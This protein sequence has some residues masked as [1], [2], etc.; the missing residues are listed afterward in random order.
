[1]TIPKGTLDF[2]TD[3][4]KHG[5]FVK[6]F[7]SCIFFDE[8]DYQV[9]W[10]ENAAKLTYDSIVALPKCELY[11]HNG[12]KFD[13]WFLLEWIEPQNIKIINGR[14]AKMT[15][16]KVTLIDSYLLIAEPL[17]NFKKTKISYAKFEKK[18]RE[19]HRNEIIR[20]M[21]DDCR[22][23]LELILGFHKILG[24]KLTIG[25]AAIQSI[26]NNNIK[27]NKQGSFHDSV[28]RPFF[29]GGR[30]ENFEVGH[31]RFK[32]PAKYIDINSAYSF[33]MTHKHPTGATYSITKKFPKPRYKNG[34]LTNGHWFAEID[35]LS[36]GA[37]PYKEKNNDLSFPCDDEVRTYRCT[38]Y[39]IQSALDNDTL[40]IIR[41]H[42]VLCPKK[43]MDFKE[44]V[45]HH[46]NERKEAKAH[47][48]KLKDLVHKKAGNSGYG[49]WATNPEKFYDW[50][51]V[52]IGTNVEDYADGDGYEWYNDIMGKSLWRR[53]ASPWAKEQ[54]YY[55]VATAA[56]ITGFVRAMLWRCLCAVDGK[57]YC[58]TDS[59]LCRDTKKIKTSAELGAWKLEMDISEAYLIGKKLYALRGKNDKGKAVRKFA[60]KGARL[61]YADI[62]ALWNEGEKVWKNKAPTFSIKRGVHFLERTL[63]KDGKAK[64]VVRGQRGQKLGRKI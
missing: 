33:A 17:G 59:I 45:Y 6:P 12:G 39:E 7:A 53:P 52:D 5:R 44:F 11:A 43:T 16:N 54:G 28:F 22:F 20:Y 38:G 31:F 14:I 26:K 3:P 27:V 37:L 35:A 63:T 47:N 10:S 15:I 57:L 62:V 48:D 58:D 61:R 24:K 4:F 18:N 19:K 55:D 64:T 51:I 40:E 13:F 8:N 32:A 1:M 2:E 49:K 46:Y 9:I 41:I 50:C 42:R 29:H 30:V 25:G 60:S 34:A 21:V 23:E 56:S 36:R